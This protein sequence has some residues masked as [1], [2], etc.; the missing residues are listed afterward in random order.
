MHSLI[1]VGCSVHYWVSYTI[2]KVFRDC[3]CVDTN[4]PCFEAIAYVL[5]HFDTLIHVVILVSLAFI[6]QMLA[7]V[8]YLSS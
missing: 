5:P 2:N 8:C 3:I 7:E 6:F 1:C 4:L